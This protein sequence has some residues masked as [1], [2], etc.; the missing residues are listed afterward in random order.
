[1]LPLAKYDMWA[2]QNIGPRSTANK[3]YIALSP[4]PFPSAAILCPSD[5]AVRGPSS[6]QQAKLTAPDDPK[7][8]SCQAI[9]QAHSVPHD[10]KTCV[11]WLIP[12]AAVP[13]AP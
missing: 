8:T 10:L 4:L 7:T 9:M 3:I 1:M 13:S 5:R 12:S 6:A 11:S 2:K